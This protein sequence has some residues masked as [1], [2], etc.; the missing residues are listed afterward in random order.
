MSQRVLCDE[1]DF[2]VDPQHDGVADA[3]C[4]RCETI[5]VLES[6]EEWIAY[7]VAQ[8]WCSPS[9][10]DTHEGV[11]LSETESSQFDEGADPC[12]I[13]IRLGNEAEWEEEAQE[14]NRV[15]RSASEV[16]TGGEQ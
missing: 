6:M 7:G 5:E 13:T 14:Y 10:C 9:Y 1:C 2:C 15:W 16:L 11:P 12:V 3:H 8:G 4:D